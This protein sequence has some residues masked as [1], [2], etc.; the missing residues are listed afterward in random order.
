MRA[1]GAA[2]LK[3]RTRY[4]RFTNDDLRFTIA[5]SKLMWLFFRVK[6]LGEMRS[7]V[8]ASV[9][10]TEFGTTVRVSSNWGVLSAGRVLLRR[11]EI[12]AASE[13]GKMARRKM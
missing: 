11:L 12:C 9:I 7:P 8:A 3:G 1:K 5:V 2:R 6:F 13:K 10:S 4:L